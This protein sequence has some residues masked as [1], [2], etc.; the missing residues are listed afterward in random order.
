MA[1]F[2]LILFNAALEKREDI[3][4][5]REGFYYS[6]NGEHTWYDLCKIITKE[7]HAKGA[8]KTDEPTTF[9]DEELIKAIGNLVSTSRVYARRQLCSLSVDNA[10]WGEPRAWVECARAR[11][12]GSGIG[13]E[14]QV[15][16]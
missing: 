4:H 14:A 16:D 11:R 15:H 9:T 7:L 6:E 2:Y 13:V 3:P 8:S 12:A 10:G 5:G 1:D